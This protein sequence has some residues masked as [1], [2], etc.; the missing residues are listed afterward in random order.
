MIA[1]LNPKPKF[2]PNAERTFFR[3]LP[4]KEAAQVAGSVEKKRRILEDNESIETIYNEGKDELYKWRRVGDILSPAIAT[5]ADAIVSNAYEVAKAGGR[6]R[7]VYTR[8]LNQR[9]PEIE[10]SIRSFAKRIKEHQ[11]KIDNPMRYVQPDI[12][13]Q[14]LTHLVSTLWPEE[15]LDFKMKIEIMKG[16]LRERN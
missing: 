12:T 2:N 1:L 13:E 5:E 16:I 14:H 9:A 3:T 15:I 6:H 4:A 10:K 7:G 8:Y 11:D